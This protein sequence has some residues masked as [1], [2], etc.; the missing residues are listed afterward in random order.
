MA[1]LRTIQHHQIPSFTFISGPTLPIDI[2][3]TIIEPT[4]SS[5]NKTALIPTCYGGRIN[6]TFT[7]PRSL[8]HHR[9]I[10]VAML[11]NGESSS[12]SKTASFPASLD[13]RD[14]VGSQYQL[15]RHLGIPS[16]DAVI[17]F[18]MGGQQ[19][20][21]W[22][23]M[24]PDY[25]ANAVV[26]CGSAK[27]SGHNIAFLEGPKSALINSVDYEDGKYREKGIKPVRGLRAFERA[28]RAWLHSPEWYREEQW[29]TSEGHASVAEN[30]DA[31]QDGV[32]DWDPED[33]LVLARMW[34]AGDIGVFSEDGRFK[35]TLANIKPRMLIMPSRTDQYFKY[36]ERLNPVSERPL[37][38][39]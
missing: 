33:L 7:F 35:T 38:T 23:A 8:A 2:A 27:T 15:C 34:Q 22:A 5:N 36:V 20:Y 12:P 32:L 18:S 1:E 24:Y 19:A 29:R 10:V 3:Y 26:I 13:Y 39:G 11:G 30:V 25:V 28:Y 4:S 16:L 31:S 6:E 37:L 17:G 21:Y 14:V 9:T